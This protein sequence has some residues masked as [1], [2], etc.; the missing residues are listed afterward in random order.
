[1]RAYLISIATLAAA[2]GGCSIGNAVNETTAA[3]PQ[4]NP[5]GAA[6]VNKDRLLK[7]EREPGSWLNVGNGYNEQRFSQL[8]QINDTN[9]AQL[10]LAWYQDIDTERGQESTPIIVDGV[11]YLT[12]AWSMVKAYDIRTGAQLWAYDPKIDRAKGSDAC[13]DVVNRGVAAWNGK[14]YLGALDGRL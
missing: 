11:M 8:D 10:G 14:I 12:T 4:N 2:L 9:V 1:M 6:A 7:F 3:A 5:V 13:C